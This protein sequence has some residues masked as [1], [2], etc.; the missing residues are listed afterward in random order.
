MAARRAPRRQARVNPPAGV[1]IIATV[2]VMA[3]ATV[4]TGTAIAATGV[5]TSRAVTEGDARAETVV[6][7]TA[8]GRT[9]GRRP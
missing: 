5:R 6:A 1:R 4:R 2:D 9:T 7:T 3:D 8:A